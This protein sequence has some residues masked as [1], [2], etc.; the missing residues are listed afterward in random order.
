MITPRAGKP[1]SLA[2]ATALLVLA[3]LSIWPALPEARAQEAHGL[4]FS[5]N[6]AFREGDYSRAAQGYETLVRQGRAGADVYYNLGN[7]Y[8]RL[9]RLGLALVNYERARILAPRDPDV[10]YNL[11]HAKGMRVDEA[12]KIREF[13]A[14]GWLAKVTGREVFIAFAAVNALFFLILALRSFRDWE[15]TW[16]AAIGLAILWAVGAF[17]GGLKGHQA[18]TDHRAVV[19]EDQIEVR[20]GPHEE[21]TLLFLLHTGTVV[22]QERMEDG[23]RL[24][25]FSQDKRGWTQAPGV[26]PIRPLGP[27]NGPT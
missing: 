16:Y 8:F 27:G 13:P 19:V 24:V 11:R 4:F 22:D 9:G 3:L 12:E 1:G 14:A 6:Q 10:D 25:R 18:A 26:E 7:A 5:A 21:D 20:A 23:W 2:G 17:A 15:W